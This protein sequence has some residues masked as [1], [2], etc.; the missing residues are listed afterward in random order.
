MTDKTGAIRMVNG[1]DD[2]GRFAPGNIGGPGRK[3]QVYRDAEN[4]RKGGFAEKPPKVT[5]LR[6]CI[7][8]SL[9]NSWT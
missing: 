2:K 1:R 8:V 6:S 7:S 3:P 5:N 9:V 4:M